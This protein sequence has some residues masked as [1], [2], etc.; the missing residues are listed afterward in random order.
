MSGFTLPKTVFWR[1]H[2]CSLQKRPGYFTLF[3]TNFTTRFCR[4]VMVMVYW[5]IAC[6]IICWMSAGVFF[7]LQQSTMYFTAL[8]GRFFFFQMS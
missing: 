6:L 7:V 4:N 3:T 8:S 5:N 2:R 1:V